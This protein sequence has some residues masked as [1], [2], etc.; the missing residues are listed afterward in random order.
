MVI[1]E[2]MVLNSNALRHL[3]E[4]LLIC[5]VRR[6]DAGMYMKNGVEQQMQQHITQANGEV[7]SVYGDPA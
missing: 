5:L 2:Y 1:K 7:Y 4:S 3:T 6:H